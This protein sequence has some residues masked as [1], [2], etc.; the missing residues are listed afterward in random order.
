MVGSASDPA[1]RDLHR[2]EL[3][4][5]V[6]LWKRCHRGLQQGDAEL[7]LPG[8]NSAVV[9]KM[10]EEL[11]PPFRGM[12]APAERLGTSRAGGQSPSP[13]SEDVAEI[14]RHEPAFLQGMDTIVSQ[15][16]AEASGTSCRWSELSWACCWLRLA[17]CCWKGCSSS[18]PAVRR[19][20]TMLAALEA[21][22][23]KL[24]A[25]RRGRVSQPGE[26]PLPGGDKPRVAFAPSRHTGHR[27][28]AS[29]DTA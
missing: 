19:I 10:F 29:E 13:P 3:G 26:K 7:G 17:Y 4:Q 21:T 15:Y 28:A 16:A 20:R 5:T 6:E 1:D 27:R 24:A 23:A 11:E 22:G 18:V 12:L 14:M 2:L 25:A 8:D 9:Q